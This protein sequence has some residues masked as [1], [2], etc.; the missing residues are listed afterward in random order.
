M[1]KKF[2]LG[3][4]LAGIVAAFAFAPGGKG[5]NEA[6][7]DYYNNNLDSLILKL[8]SL[9]SGAKHAPAD[10]TL[11]KRGFLSCRETY[12]KISFFLEQFDSRSARAINGPDLLRIEDDTQQDSTKPHGF[13]HIEAIL[14]AAAFDGN[15]FRSETGILLN[16]VQSLRTAPDHEY[17]FRDDRVWEALRSGAYRII[18]LGITG[19]DVPLSLNALPETRRQLEAERDVLGFYQKALEEKHP[20]LYAATI[21]AFDSAVSFVEKAKD[22]NSFDRLRFIREYLNPLT[23]R[24]KECAFA[25][26]AV[27]GAQLTPLN[28]EA[29]N[30]F[31]KDIF[32]IAFFSPNERFLPTPERI[33]LGK[34]LFSDKRLSRGNVRSCAS[35]HQ[36]ERAF[37]D[38]IPKALSL[39]G[40]T[41]VARNTP[42]L[43]NSAIQARQF[44]DSR[45]LVL[46]TQLD[47]VVH[48]QAEMGGS[49]R[50]AVPLLIA[51]TTYNRQFA[52]AY[53]RE[54]EKINQY[55]IANAIGSYIRSLTLLNSRFDR[56]MRRQSADFS[57]TEQRGFNL[58]MGKAK[59]GTCH[60]APMF[61]GLVPPRYEESESEILA[62]PAL[63]KR[64]STLDDD[65]GKGGTTHTPLHNYA[66]K[67]P[68]VRNA[69]LTAPYMHNG[70][71]RTLEEVVDFYNRGGGAGWGIHLETQT[72]PSEPLH[73]T[74]QEQRDIVAFVR[75]LND[76]GR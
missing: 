56:Y 14:Y 76:S 45:A 33:A 41:T 31:A 63:A 73:L 15:G 5:Y 1:I 36:P 54:R 50:D 34:R 37:T 59:C 17:Y 64:P 22:F 21:K 52:Q 55:T 35:C 38:G 27:N 8:Q 40:K 62:V 12:K 46:E 32:N 60:Y 53:S 74:A 72:L 6:V 2:V 42:T 66:F 69:A 29:E 48:N 67:T 28:A 4:A 19:F 47:A 43:I 13:Q 39:D 20:G 70:V 75:S 23:A 18:S 49:L 11:L 7:A 16:T 44:Y 58:F 25:L 3:C 71:F 68:T 65:F 24:L 30:L 51:D 57:G 61:N 26:G 10:K 9:E